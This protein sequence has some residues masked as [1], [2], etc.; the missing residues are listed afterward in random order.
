MKRSLVFAEGIGAGAGAVLVLAAVLLMT[1]SRFV[2]ATARRIE[3][4]SRFGRSPLTGRVS[5]NCL[6]RLRAA[7]W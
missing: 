4:A 5:E 1:R 2:A 6:D 3:D 7:G